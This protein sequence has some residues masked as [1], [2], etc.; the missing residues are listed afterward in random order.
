M[1]MGHLCQRKKIEKTLIDSIASERQHVT[2]TATNMMFMNYSKEMERLAVNWVT[3]CTEPNNNSLSYPGR[4]DLGI[5]TL[6]YSYLPNFFAMPGTTT[7]LCSQYNY[8]SN[9]CAFLTTYYLQIIWANTSEGG[10]AMKDCSTKR[11]NSTTKTFYMTCVFKPGGRVGDERPYKNETPCTECPSG[12][13]CYMNQCVNN[14]SELQTTTSTSS[15]PSTKI[16]VIIPMFA[17]SCFAY[18]LL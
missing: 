15:L 3:N 14:R 18:F 17:L 7:T 8:S 9:K 4:E 16:S 11:P 12:Y 2:P 1:T 13:G 5:F 6:S 10:C